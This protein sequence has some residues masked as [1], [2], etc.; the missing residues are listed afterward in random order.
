MTISD[1]L[2]LGK[3]V[4]RNDIIVGTELSLV[5]KVMRHFVV[6]EAK[7][8]FESRMT[9]YVAY[10]DLF[11]EIKEG[12]RVPAYEVHVASSKG[13]GLTVRVEEIE[14]EA[15]ASKKGSA[16]EAMQSALKTED[17]D[18]SVHP[19]ERSEHGHVRPSETSK[20]GGTVDRSRVRL[21]FN[22]KH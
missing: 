21:G 9:T 12:E 11:R 5:K 14:P 3:F 19:A 15:G 20:L 18:A 16:L 2:R 10:S 17:D 13:R 4:L 1:S 22:G 7:P 8:N 6:I